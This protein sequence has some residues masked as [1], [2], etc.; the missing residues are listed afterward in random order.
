MKKNLNYYGL[1]KPYGN[2]RKLLLIMRL[3]L[4]LLFC[5]VLNLFAEPSYSQNTRLSLNMTNATIE[6]ILNR[7]EDESEF[8]FLFNHD[9]IDVER[10]TDIVVANATIKDILEEI[11][12]DEINILVSD[13]QI[14]L[15]PIPASNFKEQF[16]EQQ[17]TVRGK[18]IDA[19]TGEPMPGV[20]IVVKGTTSGT[21]SDVN[22][23]F[24]LPVADPASAVL[25]F[26][27]VGYKSIEM[28]LEGKVSLNISLDPDITGLEE[29]VVIGYGTVQK[30]DLTGS[31]GQVGSSAIK[32]M[33]ITR[34]DQ[35]LSG[36]VAGV[37]IMTTT[38]E[39]GEAPSIRIRGVGSISAGSD[40]LYVVD[41][42][43]VD[44]IQFVN[45]ND[46]E[47][48]DVLKDASATAIYGSRGANGVVIISTKR[49]KAGSARIGFD[50]YYGWQNV[51]KL[52][53][54]LTVE[55]QAWYYY[56][57]IE[58]QNLDAGR[59]VTGDPT[60]WF[61]QV[62]QTVMDV[63]NGVN[64]NNVDALG[65]VLVTAPQA[66]YNL[67]ASGGNEGLKYNISGE[68]L[69]QDGI[70]KSSNFKRYSLRANFDA[71]LSR[72]LALKI[73]LNTAYSTRRDLAHSGGQGDGEGILGSAQTWQYWY[74]LY[75]DDGTYF[76][77]YGQD[78]TNNVWNPMAQIDLI[79][80][81][82]E[83][84]RNMGNINTEYK[85]SDDLKLNVML[86]ANM[87]N[88]HYYSFIPKTPVFARTIADGD[89]DRSSSL[90]WITETTLNYT[91]K[92]NDHNITGLLGY[93]TQKQAGGGNYLRSRDYPNN[94]VYTLN[95]A[96]NIIYQGS[97]DESEWSLISYL[98]RFNYNYKNR[99]YVTA[100]IRSDG[101]SRFGADNKY[102]YFPS[103][104][105]A[106]RISDENF[107]KS[108]EFVS[109]MKLRTS[110]GETGNNNIGNY[111]H[112]AT[113]NYESYPFGGGSLGGYAPSQFANTLLTWEKQRSSNVGTDISLFD[114]RIS[115][116][117]DYFRTINHNLLLD[118]YIPLT[119]GFN[120]SLQNI[121]KVENKGWEFT[122]ASKNFTGDF[123]WTTDFNISMFKN[124]VLQLGPEGA[125]IIST[126]H[127]TMIGQPMGMFYG[128]KLD[129]V[130]MTQAE[131]AAGPIY[132]KGTVAQSRVGDLRF[133]DISGPDGV[134]DGLINTFDKQIIGS[135]YPDFYYGMTNTFSYKNLSLVVSLQGSYG[136]E[137]F[138]TN[139]Y[140][141]Y[142]RARYKQLAVNRNY[143]KSEAEPGDGWNPRPNN[144][145]TG[146]NR[147][148]SDRHIDTGTYLKINN[149]NLG[150]TFSEQISRKV[151]LS[152]LRVYINANN[153]F[154][155]TKFRLYNPEVNNSSNPLQ[156]G[157]FNSNYPVAKGISFGLSATF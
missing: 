3:T 9:L 26:S 123:S 79:R 12:T 141:Y 94:M 67:S 112:I 131:L 145:P 54:F 18:V 78:A 150:Y 5:G 30:K 93:T 156:P 113:I 105:L 110:Y 128:Y 10:R 16:D 83:Q 14:V 115:F 138:M 129:G 15:T 43:P 65:Q 19:S 135:P 8:Y 55:E 42:Y 104:A 70:V 134:P 77:G 92:I 142:T 86:G 120:T 64:K 84:L 46:I 97:S 66:S 133:Q 4:F 153:P 106:W 147:E 71:Q 76:S 85:I 122:L 47:T 56:Y 28:P 82:E 144:S 88:R 116:S 109:D 102:G 69:D 73:N 118:V 11:F 125:P 90:N 52:P 13:R 121:G 45:P 29:V 72:K 75:N 155:F 149:M 130:F 143:W 50:T 63:L 7:I 37:Q 25:S 27:F 24:A 36:K 124:K 51:L 23:D 119:T 80:R 140:L 81:R 2:W 98:A 17:Q 101:S 127:I 74:P 95:A 100:S 22:G 44:N 53:E 33:S 89:D 20:N 114:G 107:M 87:T 34:V 58:N 49:G 38:G 40:P 96:S 137:V 61:Y 103:G 59:S 151:Y 31:V 108:L 48:I 1:F 68:Y 152:S 111:A 139:D 6:N 35:A 117:A 91:K 126:S 32:E 148:R 57:G 154:L 146:G 39:P 21:L 41:G 132:G 60:K 157:I 136:N 99:Y 62:P